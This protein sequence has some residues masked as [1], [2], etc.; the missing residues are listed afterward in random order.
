[1]PLR[2]LSGSGGLAER[3]TTVVYSTHNVQEAER[4]AGQVVV[5]ADGELLYTGSPRELE[6]IVGEEDG[7]TAD[8]DAAKAAVSSP[9]A[10]KWW[11]SS[12][13]AAGPI[14]PITSDRARA[15]I[16]SRTIQISSISTKRNS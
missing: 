15:R 7:Y 13:A 1:M 8:S 9:A 12:A 4:Y 16:P 11:A 14:A 10:Y 2:S 6:G 3:G 5:L